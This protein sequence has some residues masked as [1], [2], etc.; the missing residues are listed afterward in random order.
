MQLAIIGAGKIVK[1]FLPISS[2]IPN[3]Q[4]Q[5]IASTPHGEKNLHQLQDQYQIPQ[6]YTDSNQ[7]I[8]DPTV[9][10]VYV[11]VPNPLHFAISQ[12]ALLA[13]KNVICEKPFVTSRAEAETLEKIALQKDLILVE[14]IT[15]QYLANFF[16]IQQALTQIGT[17]RI[18]EFNYSQYSSRYDAFRAGTILPAFDPQQGGGALTDLNVYNIHLAVS[19]LGQPLDVRY[20]PN[21]QRHIDTSGILQLT[22][23][24]A[25]CVCIAAK[26]AG[27]P[28]RS[29]LE[30]EDG[31]IIIEGPTNS[32]PKFTVQIRQG[33]SK[34]YQLNKFPQKMIGEFREFER[35]IR[36][37]DLAAASRAFDHSVQVLDILDQAQTN[38]N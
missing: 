37:H 35:L 3:L 28:T 7:A 27:A 25:Q 13:G 32:L 26:D 21:R 4:I 18:A 8:N 31:T 1:E 30:G 10:T 6:A 5:A 2:Q 15:N 34:S 23:P 9:D 33:T 11:A 36:E 24:Q 22:Y 38:Y 20:F 16:G 17:I 14:A 19:L 29:L 12:A